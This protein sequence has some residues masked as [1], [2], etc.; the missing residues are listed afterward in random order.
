MSSHPRTKTA[1]NPG[2]KG[3]EAD[4]KGALLAAGHALYR[5]RGFDQVSLRDLADKAGVN[6]AMV[7]YYFKDKHGF[8]A[9]MLDQ[10]FDRLLE[11]APADDAPAAVFEALII[12]LNA[13]PWLPALMMQCVHMSTEL[14]AHFLTRH[15]PRFV[16]MLR[17]AIPQRRGLDP[18]YAVLSVISMLMFPQLA[19]PVA[20]SVFGLRFDKNFAKGFADHMAALL[21]S[22]GASHD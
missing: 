8:L 2:P 4:V 21:G 7:R 22:Q 3:G 18:S 15:A 14:R 16:A 9:A 20:G 17:G 10:G 19:R 5:D 11:A 13:M 1:S 6:Q 12:Q